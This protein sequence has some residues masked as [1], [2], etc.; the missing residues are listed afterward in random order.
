MAQRKDLHLGDKVF[1]MILKA[2]AF[3]II[4]LLIS[5]FVMLFKMSWPV[6][7]DMGTSF[8]WT[9]EWNPVTNEYGALTSIF[10][11][12]VTALLALVLSLPISLGAAILITE[13][14][15]TYIKKP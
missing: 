11:T 8:L 7:K 1:F 9:Q 5:L 10:G 2:L 15:Q 6:F 14:N 13:I 3:G 4:L 12:V